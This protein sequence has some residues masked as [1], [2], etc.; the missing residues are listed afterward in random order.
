MARSVR[1][2]A[3]TAA[4]SNTGLRTFVLVSLIA[5]LTRALFLLRQADANAP[6]SL[7]Y[8]GDAPVYVQAALAL[9]NG[10]P[11][12]SG[13]PFHPPGFIFFLAA[14]LKSPGSTQ[15]SA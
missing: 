9:L 2:G 11:Y 10:V 13:I 1:P 4:T 7:L 6:T 14:L 12:D 3:Q 5:W 15:R 8:W